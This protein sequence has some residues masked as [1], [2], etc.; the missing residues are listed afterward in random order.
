MGYPPPIP[1][2][3][4]TWKFKKSKIKL[5]GRFQKKISVIE[6]HVIITSTDVKRSEKQGEKQFI[7]QIRDLLLSV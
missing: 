4:F 6:M 1:H 2:A 5:C 3:N 7:K